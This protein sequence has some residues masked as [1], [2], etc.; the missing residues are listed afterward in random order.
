[1]RAISSLALANDRSTP[2]SL[3]QKK[4]ACKLM[5]QIRELHMYSEGVVALIQDKDFFEARRLLLL[6]KINPQYGAWFLNAC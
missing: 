1:M 2:Q 6:N 5:L 3:F 4:K